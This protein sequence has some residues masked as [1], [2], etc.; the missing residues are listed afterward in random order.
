MD[1]PEMTVQEAATLILKKIGHPLSSKELAKMVL[2]QRL[3]KSNA[4]DPERSLASTI[5]Q[6]ISEERE[7]KLVRFQGTNNEI[8]VGLPEWKDK[9]IG[10]TPW[11]EEIRITVPLELY[12]KLQLA[13]QAGLKPSFEETVMFLLESGLKQEKSSIKEGLMKQIENLQD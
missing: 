13:Q 6:N 8:L 2:K 1:T 11:W 3:V 9:V 10:Q 12:Q 4:A 7:P 5:D